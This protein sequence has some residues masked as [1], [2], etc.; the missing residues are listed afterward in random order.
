MNPIAIPPPS[1]L[2]RLHVLKYNTLNLDDLIFDAVSD[3]GDG[4]GDGNDNGVNEES[5]LTL[6]LEGVLKSEGK[7]NVNSDSDSDSERQLLIDTFAKYIF[8]GDKTASEALLMALL[9]AAERDHRY[10]NKAIQMPSGATLGCGSINFVLSDRESCNKLQERLRDVLTMIAPVVASVNLSLSA[11]N[12]LEMNINMN[13]NESIIS[14]R[15]SASNRLGPSVLQ[16]PRASCL[17]INQAKLLEGRVNHSGERALTSLK[18]IT[19]THNVP[20]QFDQMEIDFEA[21]HR[22]IVISSNER[23]A[24]GEVGSK[25]LP[26]SMTIK[27]NLQGMAQDSTM[28]DIIPPA[29]IS[30]IRRYISKCRSPHKS[31][32]MPKVMLERSQNDFIKWRKNGLPGFGRDIEEHDFHRWLLL[33]RLQARSRNGAFKADLKDWKNAIRLDG[34]MRG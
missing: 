24:S 9:S 21:D 17:L 30:R 3:S 26:C 12:G 33:T 1:L 31:V 23:S 11:L 22:V 20:Y 34:D 15:K 13:S 32:A 14:P 25:L 19:T 8:E 28:D 29:V 7:E 5:A 2:P 10:G 16:L 18:K 6:A 27:L 4:D